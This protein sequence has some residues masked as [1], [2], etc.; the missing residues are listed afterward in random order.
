MVEAAG[1]ERATRV[2]NSQIIDSENARIGKVFEVA[3]SAVLSLYG[4]FSEHP[5]LP[6]STF[7][8]PFWRK[9]F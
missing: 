8:R 2:K 5:Q 1:V 4:H 3:K 6:N 9:A 7:G